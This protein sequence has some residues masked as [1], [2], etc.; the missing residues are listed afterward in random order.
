MIP[1]DPR[2]NCFVYKSW[3]RAEFSSVAQ[4]SHSGVDKVRYKAVHTYEP[5]FGH[6]EFIPCHDTIVIEVPWMLTWHPVNTCSPF[7]AGR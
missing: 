2:K 6:F 1:S 7:N 4:S 3:S 5:P